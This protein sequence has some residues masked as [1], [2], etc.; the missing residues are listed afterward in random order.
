MRDI[1]NNLNMLVGLAPVSIA[2]DTTT[3]TAIIDMQDR[4]SLE[5][6]LASGV[7]TDG[8]YAI[9][10]E[11]GDD[12][13]LSDAVAIADV[14]LLGTEADAGFALADDGVVKKIGVVAHHGK[15][16]VRL[17]IVSTAT[18]SGGLFSVTA[19]VGEMYVPV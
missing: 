12:S 8:A 1:H 17:S 16:Y 4:D 2:T 7:I 19:V 11:S 13:G 5:F 6:V 3:V 14:H 15:R 18:T 10:V 9:L